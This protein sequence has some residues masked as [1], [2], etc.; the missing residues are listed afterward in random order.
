MK[1]NDAESKSTGR[2]DA[3]GKRRRKRYS[4]DERKDTMEKSK[5]NRGSRNRSS[6]GTRDSNDKR[7]NSGN[8]LD[9]PTH[10][11]NDISWYTKSPEQVKN[12]ANISFLTANGAILES[13]DPLNAQDDLRSYGAAGVMRLGFVPTFGNPT[14]P[15]D[16]MNIA[17][18]D[19]YAFVRHYNSGS[20]N[21]Y[22]PDFWK[23]LAVMDCA[24]SYAGYLTRA[25]GFM[26]SFSAVNRYLPK[27]V[28]RA[29]GIDW[30][31]V[32]NHISEFRTYINNYVSRINSM[33]VPATLPIFER[34]YWMSTNVY[35]DSPNLK[36]QLYL[37]VPEVYGQWNDA[38]GNLDFIKFT[39]DIGA[40]TASKEVDYTSYLTFA[41]L[42]NIGDGITNK[43]FAS[44]DFNIMSGD[45]L[46]AFEGKVFRVG[47]VASDFILAPV[48]DAA[49]LNEIMNSVAVGDLLD[50]NGVPMAKGNTIY[51]MYE[52]ISKGYC[53]VATDISN[54]EFCV[55]DIYNTDGPTND[56]YTYKYYREPI[57][58]LTVDD[59]TP[60]HIIEATRLTA[61]VGMSGNKH[62]LLHSGADVI[63]T[64][65]VF[66]YQFSN[67]SNQY[68]CVM[69]VPFTN[70]VPVV[71]PNTSTDATFMP[72][73]GVNIMSLCSHFDWHPILYPYSTGVIGDGNGIF[74]V[75]V[76]QAA[77]VDNDVLARIHEVANMSLFDVL[78]DIT[79]NK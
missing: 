18:Q 65:Q 28:I 10:A 69:T 68:E 37:F 13:V 9:L 44:E 47:G 14:Q 75:D 21:Y 19:T 7:A 46:K 45:I 53:G 40:R 8:P 1:T 3:K 77:R 51:Y 63:T 33:A 27:Q 23:Y 73:D 50:E 48:Y 11:A 58:N 29:M 54:K 22:A 42:T 72:L 20:R 71:M 74:E 43:I 79:L 39:P 17:M 16:P 49:V 35:Q 70:D 5:N 4:S 34:H 24:Y 2:T 62:V 15:H 67:L 78:L 52:D 64:Y 31:D 61:V 57:L 66:G 30:D 12:V 76:Y 55:T 25:Y 32:H 60:D 36:S 26:N 6:R 41:D 56:Y 59:P 38:T